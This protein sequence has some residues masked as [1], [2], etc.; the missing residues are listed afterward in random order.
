MGPDFYGYFDNQVEYPNVLDGE[1]LPVGTL[2]S[3]VSS[4]FVSGFLP[5][6]CAGGSDATVKRA[7]LITRYGD[8]PDRIQGPTNEKAAAAFNAGEHFHVDLRKLFSD[9]VLILSQQES[10]GIW[11]FVWC[12]R[13]VSDC[14]IGRFESDDPSAAVIEMFDKWVACLDDPGPA[15]VLEPAGFRGWVTF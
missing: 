5:Y 8:D 11:W 9:D 15:F 3:Y 10:T 6:M 2:Y 13:D 7:Y 4:T 1:I 12:D 14:C